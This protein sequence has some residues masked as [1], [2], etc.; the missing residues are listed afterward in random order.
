VPAFAVRLA[1]RDLA[2]ELL[3]SKRV[4]PRFAEA[5]GYTFAYPRLEGALVAEI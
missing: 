2:D 1:L 3:G 5:H 4:V